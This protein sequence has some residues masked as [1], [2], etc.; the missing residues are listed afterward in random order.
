MSTRT[1][2]VELQAKVGQYSSSMQ[3]AAS[4]T[5]AVDVASKDVAKSSRMSGA[6]LA[7]TGVAAGLAAK[8]IW[9]SV[10]AASDLN[11]T[12]SKSSV[13]FGDGAAEVQAFADTAATAI[14]QSKQTALDGAATFGVFGKSAGLAGKDLA[15]FSTDFVTLASDM[16]SFNNTSPEEAIDA[17]GAALRGEAEPIRRYGVLLDDASMRQEALRLGLIKTTSEALT[18]QNK[19][20]AAQEL[21]FKQTKDAQ[22]DFARTSDGLANSQR[23]LEAEFQNSKAALGQNLLPAMQGATQTAAD[24]LAKFNALPPSMQQAII[25]VG[26]LGAATVIA[27]PRIMDTVNALRELS[28]AAGKMTGA[29]SGAARMAA[30]SGPWGIAILG[31]VGIAGLFTAAQRESS[32]AIEDWTRT[33]SFQGD[34][35]DENS[36]KVLAKKLAEE[37]LL[38]VTAELGMTEKQFLDLIVAG[39]PP[40]DD[41]VNR[42]LALSVASAGADVSLGGA[43]DGAGV[44]AGAVDGAAASTGGFSTSAREAALRAEKLAADIGAVRGESAQA[45][46]ATGETAT[47]LDGVAT[48]AEGAATEVADYLTTIQGLDGGYVARQ[49]AQDDFLAS[50]DALRTSLKKNGETLDSNTEKGRANREAVFKLRDDTLAFAGAVEKQT[51]STD[52]ANKK[53]KEGRDKLVGMARQLGMTKTEAEAYATELGLIPKKVDTSIKTSVD[54]KRPQWLK[55]LMNGTGSVIPLVLRPEYVDQGLA[56]GGRLPGRATGG[57]IVAGQRY[58]VGEYGRAETLQISRDGL[59]GTVMTGIRPLAPTPNVVSA[60]SLSPDQVQVAVSQGV[61]DAL[62]AGAIGIEFDSVGAARMVAKG[63]RPLERLR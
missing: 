29:L 41:L 46:A 53:I 26:A 51:H 55:N 8:G 25:Y 15:K 43:A 6:A 9:D 28:P 36:R 33:L 47:G 4:E 60:P 59:S 16:A 38:D 45:A 37:G 61:R 57:P 14:G 10:Q 13:I 27:A 12:V 50:V 5:R 52:Q 24:L 20:L 62:L 21:I 63:Q 7:A 18:P 32:V 30:S 42:V 31:A 35:L 54:D 40:L 44:L 56:A 19:V 48:A 17:I 3:K 11:E 58:A 23:I 39:G 34:E 1:V 22:G 49:R 2:S